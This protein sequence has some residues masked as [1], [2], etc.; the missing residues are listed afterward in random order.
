M[1]T[2]KIEL[3][4]NNQKKKKFWKEA[5]CTLKG[6]VGSSIIRKTFYL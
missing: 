3:P 5:L 2:G 6:K 1:A 4:V